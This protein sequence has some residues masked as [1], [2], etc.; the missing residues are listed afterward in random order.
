MMSWEQISACAIT[1]CLCAP[2]YI[3]CGWAGEDLRNPLAL[4]LCFVLVRDGSGAGL[5]GQV[6][7]WGKEPPSHQSATHPHPDLDPAYMDLDID[8]KPFSASP[9]LSRTVQMLAIKE[10]QIEG[11]AHQHIYM[12]E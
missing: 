2:H 5:H 1:E 9:L 10:R 12:S 8:L 7:E 11:S 3:C 4:I 6:R